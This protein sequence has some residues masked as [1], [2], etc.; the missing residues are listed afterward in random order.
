MRYNLDCLGVGFARLAKRG[1][2]RK[3]C[4]NGVEEKS[5]QHFNI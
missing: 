3:W 2:W 4:E 5:S 1:F